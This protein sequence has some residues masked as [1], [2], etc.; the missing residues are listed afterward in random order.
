MALQTD[1]LLPS[2]PDRRT[3]QM[4]EL[5][6][7]VYRKRLGNHPGFYTTSGKKHSVDHIALNHTREV[8]PA[9]RRN[10]DLPV[11]GQLKVTH[12][13]KRR[14]CSLPTATITQWGRG[15][16]RKACPARQLGWVIHAT[17]LRLRGCAIG[18]CG[19][20]L[21]SSASRNL[22]RV[23]WFYSLQLESMSSVI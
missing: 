16:G 23:R 21:R 14:G 8:L 7:R 10:S 17:I 18:R 12:K 22:R 15:A 1:W 4:V 19:R 3:G 5:H 2:A 20:T 6:N 11:V 13:A 9:T